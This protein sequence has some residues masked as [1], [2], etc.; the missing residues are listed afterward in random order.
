MQETPVRSWVRKLP[1]RREWRYT[2]QY[3]WAPLVAQT[4]KNLP[5]M[6][7]MRVPSLSWED[8]LEKV[9][10][11]HSSILAWRIPMAEEPGS[12][13]S[14]GSQRIRHDWATYHSTAHFFYRVK[15]PSLLHCQYIFLYFK[16]N[17]SWAICT[18]NPS[19]KIFTNFTLEFFSW[20]E[21]HM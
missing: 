5:A 16:T 10:A 21:I 18:L 2:P 6:Q 3:S 7:E 19:L 1:W 4:V 17:H 15:L 14:M 13:Q 11:T 20:N 12:L 8:P 9:M